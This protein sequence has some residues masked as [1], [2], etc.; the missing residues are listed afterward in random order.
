MNF[1]TTLTPATALARHSKHPVRPNLNAEH[2]PAPRVDYSPPALSE[3]L[4]SLAQIHTTGTSDST[5]VSLYVKIAAPVHVRVSPVD[6]PK[7]P[8]TFTSVT[9]NIAHD[10]AGII[11]NFM[12][13][14]TTLVGD[15][16]LSKWIVV[17]LGI[18]V[19]LNGYL[20][21]GIAAGM[22][23]PGKKS[24]GVRFRSRAAFRTGDPSEPL[25]SEEKVKCAPALPPVIMPSIGPVVAEAVPAPAPPV[26]APIKKVLAVD[27]PKQPSQGQVLSM[28]VD[29]NTVD[30]K[31][32]KE[33]LAA[34]RAERQKTEDVRPLAELVEIFEQGPR[35]VSASLAL[36]TDEEVILL[37]Q[38]GKIAAYALEKVLNDLERAV[39][40]R[41]ALICKFYMPQLLLLTCNTDCL[42]ASSCI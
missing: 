37:C 36:L 7:Q 14:W 11:E 26:A 12:S 34:E 38:T 9:A 19:F 27:V 28:P 42:S 16:V 20:L 15:P 23:L 24:G 31:L 21:K 1:T 17:I 6:A 39:S 25:D 29:L 22:S 33:R 5:D 32:E 30:A 3:V 35:P 13:S 8:I 18:S 2:L 10:K 41:R 4:A 40:I